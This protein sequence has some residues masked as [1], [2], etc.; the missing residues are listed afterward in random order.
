VNGLFW[1]NTFKALIDFQKRE[2]LEIDGLS[3][4][5]TNRKLFWEKQL[6]Q[7]TNINNKISFNSNNIENLSQG[8]QNIE[9]N[10]EYKLWINFSYDS[11]VDVLSSKIE[12]WKEWYLARNDIKWKEKWIHY[13]KWAFWKY[14]FTTETLKDYW[15]YLWDPP[16]EENITKFLHNSS[17]QEQIMFRYTNNN[18]KRLLKNKTFVKLIQWWYREVELALAAWH[19]WWYWGLKKYMYWRTKTKDWLGTS[20]LAYTKKFSQYCDDNKNV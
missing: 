9:T 20:I 11:Y 10:I 4:Y 8:V 5:Y 12:S 3:W 14:Q 1:T 19:I 15:V 16:K 18:L 17:L 13:S 2:W 7:N 6:N